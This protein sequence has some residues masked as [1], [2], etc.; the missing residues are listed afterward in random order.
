MSTTPP[1]RHPNVARV[2]ELEMGANLSAGTRFAS[3]ARNVAGAVGAQKLG[4][5]WFEVAPGKTAYPCHWHSAIEEA[6]YVLE[7]E[8]TVRIGKD[9]VAVAAGDY[10]AFPCGPD[11]AHQL[12]N[13]GAAPLRYLC[14][15]TRSSV[16]VVGYPDTGKIGVFGMAAPGEKP[17]LRQLHF[18]DR[19]VGYFDGERLDE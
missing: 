2:T 14:F 5:N 12:T 3:N 11:H 15:S 9:S 1:R 19:Q 16:E 18:E 17:W 7:G 13:T 4:C 10:I 6:I 8:G